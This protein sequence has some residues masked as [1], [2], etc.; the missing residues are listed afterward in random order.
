M[1][2]SKSDLAFFKEMANDMEIPADERKMY[3]LEVD[4]AGILGTTPTPIK[5]ST[6]KKTTSK[7]KKATTKDIDS[8]KAEIKK[9]TGKTEEECEKI[10]EE[11]RALRKKATT[12]K[13]KEKA[14]S[15]QSKKRVNKLKKDKKVIEGTTEKDVKTTIDD[16][17]EK[18]TKKIDK[19]IEKAEKSTT[20]S[21]K[22]IKKAIDK[23]VNDALK[24]SVKFIADISKEMDK[25]DARTYLLG[26][27]S[28][29]DALLKKYELGGE[30]F[31]GS[32]DIVDYGGGGMTQTLDIQ[33]GLVAV[34]NN[35]AS[36]SWAYAHGGKTQGYND[37]GDEELGMSNGRESG[38][39][40]SQMDRR[41]E[42]K[43]ENRSVGN[44][45]YGSFKKGGSIEKEFFDLKKS[46]H[47]D[48]SDNG[49]KTII[50]QTKPTYE[51]VY[52]RLHDLK[53][54]GH[55]DIS[56]TNIEI[57]ARKFPQP[58]TYAKGGKTDFVQ[59]VVKSKNFRKGDFTEKAKRRGMS[60]EEFQD[61]VLANTNKYDERTR[62][63]AQFMKNAF[64]Q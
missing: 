51:G 54:K 42:M 34:G 55:L 35:V 59:K 33:Q 18:A 46:N 14:Q 5:K 16:A 23:I 43:G 45:T 25:S 47:I 8:L 21:P 26:M 30:V 63:Q 9:R 39:R 60:A 36:P 4:K 27:R 19:Q 29:I 6:K 13:K 20:K 7:K 24:S 12:R 1:A 56:N 58:N 32:G 10:V 61:K 17:T 11:Y 40:Q 62:K 41:D 44:R 37:R 3:Q 57:I 48:L 22:A 53:N 31:D 64:N 52:G 15:D 2:I 28:K 49:I 38:Y 50:A